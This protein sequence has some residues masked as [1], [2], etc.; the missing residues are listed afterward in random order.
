M[1]ERELYHLHQKSQ[2]ERREV[3]Q[4]ITYHP[5]VCAYALQQA[6]IIKMKVN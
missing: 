1:Q 2:E 5:R 3:E 4:K 6:Q